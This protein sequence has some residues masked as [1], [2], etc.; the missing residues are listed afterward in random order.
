MNAILGA[1]ALLVGIVLAALFGLAAGWIIGA[2][3]LAAPV[4]FLA[5]LRR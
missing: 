5:R 1:T 3:V 4:Y 2:L